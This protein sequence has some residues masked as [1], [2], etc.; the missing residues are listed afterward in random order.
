MAFFVTRGPAWM[1]P[2]LSCILLWY[3]CGTGLQLKPEGGIIFHVMEC[4]CAYQ[5]QKSILKWINKIKI[6]QASCGSQ[7]QSLISHIP[8]AQRR[9]KAGASLWI[10]FFMIC[11][12]VFCAHEY[13]R[14]ERFWPF[15]IKVYLFCEAVPI[16][17]I[18][19]SFQSLTP[20][21]L[22]SFVQK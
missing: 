14:K 6:N 16:L 17:K 20:A 19:W 5:E 11:S 9:I 10:L 7:G 8:L 15:F 21:W 1:W 2:S 13:V 12:R 3:S 4:S 18:V 22:R